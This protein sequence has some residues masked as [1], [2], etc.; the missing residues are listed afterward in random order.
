MSDLISRQ[1][2]YET[3][4]EYYHHKEQIQHEALKEA[5][6]RVPSA[7]KHGKWVDIPHNRFRHKCSE[8]K[9]FAP[10][11]YCGDENLT[12]YCPN[13]GAKM[14]DD[15]EEPEINPCRGC[16]DYDGRGG[17]KSHGGCG[18]ERSEDERT[19]G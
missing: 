12:D 13:C 5:L 1:A 19:C 15:W 16:D 8:C 17:C 3:L 4:T 2:A 14:D 18:A 10:S 6:D 7:E 9:N 11:Y